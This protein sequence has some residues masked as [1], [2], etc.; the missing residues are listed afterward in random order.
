[1]VPQIHSDMIR[2]VSLAVKEPELSRVP[3][4]GTLLKCPKCIEFADGAD[5]FWVE[6]MGSTFEPQ[7]V[8][9]FKNLYHNIEPQLTDL[10]M[11]QPSI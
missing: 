9:N 11:I 6:K 5:R 10:T 7:K 3:S 8:A 4:L 1:M 2:R